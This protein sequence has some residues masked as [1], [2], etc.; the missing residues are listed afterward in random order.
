M[1]QRTRAF[2][3]SVIAT[4]AAA[5]FAPPAIAAQAASSTTVGKQAASSTYVTDARTIGH[6]RQ[7]RPIKAYFRGN[8]KADHQVLVLGQMHGNEP[9]GPIVASFIKNNLKPRPGTGMWVILSMNPDGRARYDRQN[10]R[11]VDLNRNWPTSGWSGKR[12]SNYWGGPKAASEPETVAMMTFL[13]DVK[14]DFIASIHQPFG[15]VDTNHKDRKYEWRLMKALRLP[16]RPVP[17]SGLPKGKVEPTLTGWYNTATKR[18]GTSVTIELPG[19]A[20]NAYLTQTVAPGVMRATLLHK[21]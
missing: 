20:S 18:H 2:H 1:R 13:K 14:P 15:V 5:L 9:A 10:A 4:V 21:W 16:G 12:S 6:S 17:I 7:G 8:P 3:L 19:S 11:N